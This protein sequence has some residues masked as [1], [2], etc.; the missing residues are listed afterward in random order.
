MVIGPCLLLCL[1]LS[2]GCGSSASDGCA[3]DAPIACIRGYMNGQDGVCED[4]TAANLAAPTCTDGTWTC[5][6]DYLLRSACTQKRC[7]PDLEIPSGPC[8]EGDGIS[9]TGYVY[10]FVSVVCFCAGTWQCDR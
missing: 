9:C 3:A 7:P 2:A 8:Q 10:P 5:P 4:E 6:T 1:L